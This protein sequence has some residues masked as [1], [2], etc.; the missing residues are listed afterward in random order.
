VALEIVFYRRA[1][2]ELQG[3][4]KSDRNRVLD[5]LH[6]FAADPDNPRH[7]VIALVGEEPTCRLR[8]GDWR[9]LFDRVGDRIEVRGV[10]HRRE[11][12]R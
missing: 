9:V 11:A 8:V 7:A 5:R 10:R 6:A 2:K 4:P 1:R 3:L 12:Y